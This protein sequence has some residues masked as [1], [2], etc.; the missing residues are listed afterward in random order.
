MAAGVRQRREPRR[1]S[2][3]AAGRRRACADHLPRARVGARSPYR[4]RST[5]W[6]AP[7]RWRSCRTGWPG[8][9]EADADRLAAQLGDLPLAIAQAAGFMAETGTPA[10]AV[11]GP[12]ADPGRAAPGPGRPRD[13]YPRSLA[14]ATQLIADRLDRDD[15][16]AA[17]AGQPVRVPGPRADPRRPVHRRRRRAARRAGGPG[18]RPAGLA[19]DPGPPGPP[20]AGPGRP[21]RAADC[22]GSPRPSSAT[23]SPPPRPPPPGRATE[24]ILAASNPGDPDNPSTW[25]RWARLMPHLLAADLAATDNPALRRM[26][27]NGVPVPAGARRHP[28]RP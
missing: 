25:P 4:S 14:A 20:V 24:A 9:A 8:S 21:A 2:A 22:T 3:V 13:R 23:A 11:P 5:C 7:N 19:A 27:C 16:A 28:Q 10:A 26:A 15:P 18:G 12:A 17:A 1:R 6:P